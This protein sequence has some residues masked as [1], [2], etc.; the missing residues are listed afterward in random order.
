MYNKYMKKLSV[1]LFA[2]LLL[3]ATVQ[4]N[5]QAGIISSQKARIEQNRINKSNLNAIKNVI[6]QQIVFTNKYDLE[7]LKTLYSENF[8]NSDGFTKGDY[9][10]LIKETWDIYPDIVYFTDIKNIDFNDNYASVL[11]QESAIATSKEHLGDFTAIGELYSTSKCIYYLEKQGQKWLISSEKILEET[12]SL[13][14]GDARYINMELFAPNQTGA[15]KT[16]TATLK[17]DS[18][19]NIIADSVNVA[20]QNEY[21]LINMDNKYNSMNSAITS[22]NAASM[23]NTNVGEKTIEKTDSLLDRMPTV[24]HYV[25]NAAGIDSNPIRAHLIQNI[26]GEI[27]TPENAMD[28]INTSM[29]NN[30]INLIKKSQLD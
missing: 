18:S 17:V 11:V 24:H 28:I 30:D 3:T 9:F 4:P 16:Y 26:Q 14:Y 22:S 13:K 25:R 12:S 8:V 20:R 10:K 15:G 7:G 27:V 21:I 6:N 23:K 1:L 29:Q 2:A 19:Y 5:C